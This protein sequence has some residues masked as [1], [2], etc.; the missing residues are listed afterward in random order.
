MKSIMLRSP[1]EST[2]AYVGINIEDLRLLPVRTPSMTEQ[3]EIV[4]HLGSLQEGTQRLAKL[5]DRKLAALDA[6]KKSLL[7]QAFTGNL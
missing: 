5:Y 7:H 4:S 2:A 1:V 3:R 6:L